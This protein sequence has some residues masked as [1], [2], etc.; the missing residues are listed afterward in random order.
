VTIDLD[1]TTLSA[2]SFDCH[3]R[4]RNED[5]WLVAWRQADSFHAACGPR[6]LTEALRLFLEWASVDRSPRAL[7]PR[8]GA[9][10]PTPALDVNLRARRAR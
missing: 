8:V 5:D 7:R 2:R 9:L 4:H 6:N 1:G 10:S 3:E